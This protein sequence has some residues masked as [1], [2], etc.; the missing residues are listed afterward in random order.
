MSIILAI[1]TSCDD[2]SIALFK[3]N[4]LLALETDTSSKEYN[5]LGGIVPEIAAR[6]HEESINEVFKKCLE[7]A[8]ININDI[9][10]I[11]YTATPG[12]P[13]SLHVGKIFAKSLSYVLNVKL[14]PIDHMMG[15]LYSF[16]IGHKEN[17]KFPFLGLVVSGG[18]TIL[19]KLDGVNDHE[20]INA[21]TDD[22]VGEVLDKIGRALE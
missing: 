3:D 6:K 10:H 11:A 15:H 19:Y 22:A 4:E 12:L 16:G 1:E 7:H 13:G 14:I 8:K 20:I 17:I 21:T 18:N 5:K 9:T 2:T